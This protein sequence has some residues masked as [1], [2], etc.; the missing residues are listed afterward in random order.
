MKDELDALKQNHTWDIFSCPSHIK[1]IGC[2]WIYSVKLKSD[3]SLA[4]YKA[5]LV[6]LGN[7]REYGIDYDETFA[8]TAKMT[9]VRILPALIASQ[10]WPFFQMDVKNANIEISKKM[11]IRIFL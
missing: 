5:Q 7:R 9:T 4:R 1:P 8:P 10:S 11:S 3:S 6:A 2:K